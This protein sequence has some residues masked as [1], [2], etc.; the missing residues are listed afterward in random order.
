MFTFWNTD[1]L[2]NQ[3]WLENFKTKINFVLGV[4]KK[5]E[6]VYNNFIQ[7]QFPEFR[8]DSSIIV[9]NPLDVK[10]FSFKIF[11]PINFCPLDI[12]LSMLSFVIPLVNSDIIWIILTKFEPSPLKNSSRSS[13][14][15]I[16][17]NLKNS[18]SRE[19]LL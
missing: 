2:S 1:E 16:S 11:Y 12:S 6:G 10:G 19:M 5:P 18:G 13:V 9:K 4:F 7:F 15:S 17:L 8:F 14:Q 3:L